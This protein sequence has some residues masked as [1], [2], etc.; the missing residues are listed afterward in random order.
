MPLPTLDYW[1]LNT[2]YTALSERY[3]AYMQKSGYAKR[4]AFIDKHHGQEEAKKALAEI[5]S[6]KMTELGR[7]W[8]SM[9]R[10]DEMR[11]AMSDIVLNPKLLLTD[12]I[13]F[14]ESETVEHLKR[15]AEWWKQAQA[16]KADGFQQALK[17]ESGN[18]VLK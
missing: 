1:M 5:T 6:N 3:S 17:D 11:A 9:Q 18:N 13:N 7:I 16:K 14:G 15:T 10:I 4:I 12:E 8:Q 2:I